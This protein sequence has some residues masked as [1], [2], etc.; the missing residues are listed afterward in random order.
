MFARSVCSGIFPSLQYRVTATGG[1]TS[2]TATSNVADILPPAVNLVKNSGFENELNGWTAF[3][4]DGTYRSTTAAA[5]SGAYS[6][7]LDYGSGEWQGVYQ[8]SVAVKPNTNYI[9]TYYYKHA[10]DDTAN[11]CYCFVRAGGSIYDEEII[12]QAYM[13][14]GKN[15]EWKKETISFRTGDT[16]ALCID[17]RVVAGTHT[18]IDDVE[19]YEV[20]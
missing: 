5:H 10:D 20:Q 14:G 12:G 17:F 9:L 1:G 3:G 8:A 7:E 2:V 15:A 4:T 18:Y 16:D 19:L 6:L 13:N 11:N